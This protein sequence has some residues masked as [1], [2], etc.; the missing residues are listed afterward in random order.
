M[1]CLF[2]GGSPR[3]TSTFSD[4]A[5]EASL[6]G[7][8]GGGMSKHVTPPSQTKTTATRWWPRNMIIATFFRTFD[9]KLIDVKSIVDTNLRY[10]FPLAII[11]LYILYIYIYFV[12]RHLAFVED[13]G[14]T[15]SC[16]YLDFQAV[17]REYLL[18][19]YERA[20]VWVVACC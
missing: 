7:T 6:Q 18:A 15:S 12:R 9:T 14:I 1:A 20:L 4:G 19:E 17:R 16:Q 2:S 8:G 3:G 5:F 13:Q 10:T 11:D